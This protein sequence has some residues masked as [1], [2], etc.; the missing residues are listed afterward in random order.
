[1]FQALHQGIMVH[2]WKHHVARLQACE[3]KV[4]FRSRMKM[5]DNRTCL[6]LQK[7]VGTAVPKNIRTALLHWLNG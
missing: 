7:H 1:M 2:Q 3:G 4:V 6:S 5:F